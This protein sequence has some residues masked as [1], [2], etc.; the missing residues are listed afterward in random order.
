MRS[1]VCWLILV[2]TRGGIGCSASTDGD[3]ETTAGVIAI[4]RD[5][6]RLREAQVTINA[7]RAAGTDVLCVEMGWP[8]DG[9]ARVYADLACYGSSRLVGAALL[10]LIEGELA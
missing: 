4:G 3:G 10:H 2:S 5:M 8:G 1:N 9:E 7:L 6:H